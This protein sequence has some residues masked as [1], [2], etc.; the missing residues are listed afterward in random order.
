[1]RIPYTTHSPLIPVIRLFVCLMLMGAMPR[2]G[3][4]QTPSSD[5]GPAE[6]WEQNCNNSL[7]YIGC[8][9]MMHGGPQPP[10]P[11][12]KPDVWGAIAVSPSKLYR[13]WADS[14]K[15]MDQAAAGALTACQKF[16]VKDCKIVVMVAD[17]CVALV[18]S[19]ATNKYFV[20]GPAGASNF[21]ES[22][23]TLQCQRSGAK[24]CQVVDSFCADGGKRHNLNGNTVFQNGNPIFRPDNSQP[25]DQPALHI[26]GAIPGTPQ[27]P[28][29]TAGDDTAR[30]YGSWTA[31]IPVNGTTLTLHSVHDQQGYHNTW[32][33]AAGSSDAGSGTFSAANGIWH[34]NAAKPNDTGTYHFT[35]SNTVVCTN[36]LGQ[37]V[38]Y[39]R[40]AQPPA[41]TPIPNTSP[42]KR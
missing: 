34:S 26:T 25:R 16:G 28:A 22:N 15:T 6:Q 24:D 2:I 13:G 9:N 11:P 30:F 20:G 42:N 29:A 23:G 40:I 4:S 3:H 39:K 12:P 18:T 31:A 10:G 41:P 17:V 1:M 19:D 14:F 36:A 32:V 7:G 37:A 38:T 35:D 21:A 5:L 33:S 27:A 8:N